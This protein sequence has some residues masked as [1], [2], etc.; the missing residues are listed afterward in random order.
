MRH[1]FFFIFFYHHLFLITF[2]FGASGWLCIV[3]VAFTGNLHFI[4]CFP[5]HQIP[6]KKGS[7]LK[8]NALL[9]MV[10]P[11]LF[12]ADP[13]QKGDKINLAEL[14]PQNVYLFP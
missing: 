13:V 7:T 10:R 8:G 3:V 11:S 6:S 9:P 12:T 4:V 1:V 5:A 2:S 14:C